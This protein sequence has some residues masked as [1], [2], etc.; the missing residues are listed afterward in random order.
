MKDLPKIIPTADFTIYKHECTRVEKLLD[1]WC[2]RFCI[3]E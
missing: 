3:F 1:A 2:N